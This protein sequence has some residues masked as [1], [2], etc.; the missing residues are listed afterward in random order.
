MPVP[1]FSRPLSTIWLS[2]RSKCVDGASLIAG[3]P[4]TAHLKHLS[5]RS[6]QLHAVDRSSSFE[7]TPRR[8]GSSASDINGRC[9]LVC[10]YPPT[11]IL[12][13]RAR[14]LAPI[15]YLSWDHEKL[16][17]DFPGNGQPGQTRHGQPVLTTLG[18]RSFRTEL[19]PSS[20]TSRD[21]SVLPC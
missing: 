9:F 6:V 2:T 3:E 15:S 16:A 10:R 21:A 14:S 19:P 1:I 17:Q 7:P 11:S 20:R 4:H 12:T 8:H 5:S 18:A 13:R